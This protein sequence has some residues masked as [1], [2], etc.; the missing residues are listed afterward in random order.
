MKIQKSIIKNFIVNTPQTC[1][2]CMGHFL[3][4]ENLKMHLQYKNFLYMIF[5]RFI[6][7]SACLFSSIA[8]FET[9]SRY[10]LGND[11]KTE[12]DMSAFQ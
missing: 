6:S 12:E 8:R 4:S 3:S 9:S 10:V 7:N 1:C 5:S 2:K 11:L